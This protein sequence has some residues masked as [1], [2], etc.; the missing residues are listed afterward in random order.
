MTIARIAEAA[1]VSY[2]TAWRVINNQPCKSEEAIAAVRRAMHQL[3]YDGEAKA[4][5]RRGRPSRGE[6]GIRTRNIAL[7][8]LRKGSSLSTSVL[9]RVQRMLAEKEMNLI[10]AHVESPDAMPP[11]VKA[12]NVDGILGYGQFPEGAVT[13][14]LKKIPAVWMMSRSDIKPDAWG[15]RVRPDHDAIGKLAAQYLLDRGHKHLAYMNPDA[16]VR[17]YQDRMQSFR[18][19]VASVSGVAMDVYG[20]TG[21]QDLDEEAERLVDLWMKASPRPTGLFVPVDRV[22]VRVHQNLVRRGIRPGRDVDIVSCDREKELLSLASPTPASIDLH[23]TTIA[24]LAVEQ[25]FW[26]MKNGMNSPSVV[27]TVT[28]TLADGEAEEPGDPAE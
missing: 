26:R 5:Q 28:P 27:I 2:A 6:L 3:G 19:A 11:A 1:K 18:M 7:L 17:I 23:R 20:T 22:T 13:P 15:D 8:H 25:L 16:D 9:A 24:R 14:K 4:Q 10:F 21:T 12:G